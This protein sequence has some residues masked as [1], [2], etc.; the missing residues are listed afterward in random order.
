MTATPEPTRC[1]L[2]GAPEPFGLSICPG[3]GGAAHAVGD[4]LVFVQ[5]ADAKDDRRAVATRLDALLEGRTH[6]GDRSL[7]A[8]GHRALIRVPAAAADT[9]VRQLA[10]RGIPA[11]ARAARQTWTSVP[12]PFYLLLAAVVLVGVLAGLRAEPM[13]RWTSPAFAGLLV[14]AAQVRLRQP[15]IGLAPRR[16][17]FPKVVERQMAETFARLP[18]GNARDFLARLVQAAEPVHRALHDRPHDARRGDIRDLLLHA[19]RA[20]EDLADLER[21]LSALQDEPG[22]DRVA[23][24]HDGLTARFRH[25]ITVLHRLRAETVDDDP[26]VHELT[27]LVQALDEDAAA[28]T[29]A[30]EVLSSLLTDR[31]T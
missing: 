24:L 18:D 7:I 4:T 11:V 22:L 17:V 16:R 3:C 27:A 25:G 23:A 26:A 12:L 10:L 9:A 13:L 31:K 19:C 30:R 21:G 29:A 2:C 1:V 28:R 8:A 20:A 14:L 6:R 5:P 15:A